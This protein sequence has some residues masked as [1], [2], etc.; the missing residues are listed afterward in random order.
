MNGKYNKLFEPFLFPNGVSIKNRFVMAPMTTWSSNDDLTISDDEVQ[1]YSSRVNG[2]GLVITGCTHVTP[3]GQGF[4]NEFAGYDDKF[5]PSLRN[6][7]DVTKRSGNVSVLQIFHA[8]SKAVP[9]LVPN[10]DVVSASTVTSETPGM[11]EPRAISHEEILDM[12]R[13]FGET[14]RRAIE[15]GFDGV[16]IHGAHGFLIQNF[17]SPMSNQRTDQWGGSLENRLR[18]PLAI[19]EEIKKVS[20]EHATKPFILGYR[21][22]P[23]ENKEGGLRMRDT[24]E[25]IDRLVEQGLDYVHASLDDVFAKPL[26]GESEK[27]RMEL[28]LE[29]VNGKIP[30]IAAGSIKTPNDALQAFELGLPLLALG[31]SLIIN[32]EWVEM[33]ADG[34]EDQIDTELRIS[35]L[36]ELGIPEKLWE[37]IRDTPGW[38]PI[39]D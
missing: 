4:S 29:R 11:I 5:I 19:V 27:S 13:A 9:E 10:M 1:Y 2:V 35:K 28:I 36:R 33:V 39:R 6:L 38:F 34:R 23:E 22:S 17:Y 31:K 24:Y 12:I 30:V 15:A 21:I 3:N 8:G 25:L 20:K 18:F 37:A 26:D 14:T 32:P 7:A 16:E